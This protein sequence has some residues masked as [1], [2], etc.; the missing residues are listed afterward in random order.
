MGLIYTNITFQGNIPLLPVESS[1]QFLCCRAQGM[2][3]CSTQVIAVPGAVAPPP[4]RVVS[5]VT[6]V[7][8]GLRWFSLYYEI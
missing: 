4:L 5:F 6:S 2:M 8:E 7:G 3:D 1:G